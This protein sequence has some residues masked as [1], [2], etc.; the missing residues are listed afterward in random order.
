[1]QPGDQALTSGAV[2]AR[3]VDGHDGD[4]APQGQPGGAGPVLLAGLRVVSVST[5]MS[6]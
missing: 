5:A 1:M 6:W 3:E 4:A 2:G